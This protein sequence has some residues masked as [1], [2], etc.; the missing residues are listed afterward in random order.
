MADPHRNREI[1]RC[2][3]PTERE[4][5]TTDDSAALGS[6]AVVLRAKREPRTNGATT[7]EQIQCNIRHLEQLGMKLRLCARKTAA[8]GMKCGRNG[9]AGKGKKRM[10]LTVFRL[11]VEDNSA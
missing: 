3:M 9:F 4:D 8:T 6:V 11:D 2:V 1:D 5:V 7:I 10:Q